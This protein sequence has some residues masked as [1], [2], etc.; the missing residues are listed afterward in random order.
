MIYLDEISMIGK[1]RWKILSEFKMLTGIPF[2]LLGDDRQLPPVEAENVGLINNVCDDADILDEMKD[3]NLN[4]QDLI[5]GTNIT[6]LNKTRQQIN[7]IVQNAIKPN[8][9]IHIPY[10][11]PK[12][13]DGKVIEEGK[14][15]HQDAYIFTGAKLIMWITPKCKTFK[16]NECVK[17]IEINGDMMKVS[18]GTDEMDFIINDFHKTF[19]LGYAST[20]HK[21]QGDTCDG[22][23]NIF[24]TDFMINHLSNDDG[25][26]WFNHPVIYS[27]CN[28]VKCELTQM[29]RYDLNLWN[30]LED[31]CESDI[32][33]RKAIYTAISRARSFKNVKIRNLNDLK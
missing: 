10:K 23:V 9:A 16:K 1:H 8:D 11:L 18:N 4:I 12:T 24:D 13:E 27:L 5:T 15:Y 2:M 19:L 31:I 3:N 17:V 21:S 22:V 14:K 26:D 32:G 25:M 20:I 33:G 7:S 6:Y 30:K 29:K 28:G